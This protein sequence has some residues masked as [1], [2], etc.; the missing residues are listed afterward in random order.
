MTR[1]TSSNLDPTF[2]WRRGVQMAALNWQSLDE[3]TML[4]YGMFGG[5]PGW[6]LKPPGYRSSDS[7]ILH[8]TVDLTIQAFA[9]HGLASSPGETDKEGFCPYIRCQLHV[10]QLGEQSA[11][12]NT[13]TFSNVIA[14]ATS[15][16]DENEVDSDKGYCSKRTKASSG[17]NPDFGGEELQLPRVSGVVQELSFVRSVLSLP[18]VLPS[19][20]RFDIMPPCMQPLV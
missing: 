10:E 19:T 12:E 15:H 2:C 8:R 11:R 1:I 13:S 5:G 7:A 16:K 14:M 9:G 6:V 17:I 20:R 4:N 3:G 18:S